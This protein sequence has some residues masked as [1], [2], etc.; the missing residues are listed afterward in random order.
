MQ[1]TDSALPVLDLRQL[2]YFIALA[3]HGSISAAANPYRPARS[4]S[5]RAT[6]AAQ[7]AASS[8]R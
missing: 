7:A 6:I 5:T 8:L 1:K 3:E 4:A 2:H